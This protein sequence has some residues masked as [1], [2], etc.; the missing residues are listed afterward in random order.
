MRTRQ[1]LL[2]NMTRAETLTTDEQRQVGR[3]MIAAREAEQT[4][5][6]PAVAAEARKRRFAARDRLVA[7]MIP[8]V[9]K[10]SSQRYRDSRY[11]VDDMI[12]QAL[13]SIV[14]G[15]EH[16]DPE[17]GA[18]TTYLMQWVYQ[19]WFEWGY[20]LHPSIRIPEYVRMTMSRL[21]RGLISPSDIPQAHREY[22]AA[23]EKALGVARMADMGDPEREVDD[24][25][26][27]R[28]PSPL[29]RLTSQE[30]VEQFRKLVKRIPQARIRKVV[31]LR[32]GITGKCETFADVGEKIGATRQYAEQTYQRGVE[33]LERHAESINQDK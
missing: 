4:A 31:Q 1:A 11:E 21:Q 23:A 25:A 14:H 32:L 29:D 16:Y 28:E 12:G 17:I 10:R 13:A 2:S 27:S 26:V 24:V 20:R 19:G 8:W 18:A 6:D 15:V 7:I 22:V 5:T 30:E 33:W 9:V 3:E